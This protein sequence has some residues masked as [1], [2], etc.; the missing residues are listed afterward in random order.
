VPMAIYNKR[1]T[2]AHAVMALAQLIHTDPTLVRES[3]QGVRSAPPLARPLRA[4]SLAR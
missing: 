3:G 1:S 4:P 2:V